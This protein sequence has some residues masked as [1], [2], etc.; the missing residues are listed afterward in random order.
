MSTWRGKAIAN[1]RSAWAT[2]QVE[3][4]AFRRDTSA[5]AWN[6]ENLEHIFGQQPATTSELCGCAA[7]FGENADENNSEYKLAIKSFN[8]CGFSL[9]ACNDLLL[10]APGIGH[11]V[12]LQEPFENHGEELMDIELHDCSR[13]YCGGKRLHRKATT[14]LSKDLCTQVTA[15]EQWSY[16][17]T[18]DIVLPHRKTR[19]INCHLP[20]SWHPIHTFAEAVGDLR[21]QCENWQFD[22]LL[23]GDLNAELGSLC[24]DTY[25]GSMATHGRH[26]DDIMRAQLLFELLVD[27]GLVAATTFHGLTGTRP[28]PPTRYHWALEEQGKTLDYICVRAGAT[29]Q[30][31]TDM[32][33]AEIT[34]SDH[35]CVQADLSFRGTSCSLSPPQSSVRK[36]PRDWH[37]SQEFTKLMLDTKCESLVQ[38]AGAVYEAAKN[39]DTH[40]SFTASLRGGAQYYDGDCKYDRSS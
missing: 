34:T 33:T 25:I 15:A 13:L 29:L 12:C 38:L 6:R 5:W 7:S 10:L 11:I 37:P 27:Y 36:L 1:L 23:A 39:S 18:V 16:G 32:N 9:K 22:I 19:I 14:L 30:A 2:G 4:G 17:I 40:L 24:D 3:V 31:T 21:S 20:N 8:M 35:I 28:E 26:E